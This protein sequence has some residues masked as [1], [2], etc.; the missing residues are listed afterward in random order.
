MEDKIAGTILG[1]ALGDALGA[2][3]E[4][5]PYSHYTGE[6]NTSIVRYTR[7]YGEQTSSIGQVTDDT[8]MA[9][10]LL[11]TIIGGYTRKKA[12]INYMTWAINDYPNCKG[13][14]PF[15]GK[16]TR[17]LFVATKPKVK[18]YENRFDKYYPDEK[19]KEDS[20][21]NGALMRSYPLAFVEDT[22]IIKIDVAISNPSSLTH[23]SVMAYIVAIKMA[24]KGETK[25]TIKSHV[26]TILKNELLIEVYLDACNNKF[27][28]VTTNREHVI[29]AFYCAFWGLF[30]YND[31]KTAIDA[32]ICLSPN[33]NT[34]AKICVKGAALKKNKVKLG[35]TDTNAAIA[36]ALLGAFYG[37]KMIQV[38]VTTRE[39]IETL[40]DCDPNKGDIK[41]PPGLILNREKLKQ[42][43]DDVN[44]LVTDT[45]ED[46]IYVRK[47]VPGDGWC[48]MHAVDQ[49]LKYVG[50]F[51]KI[52]GMNEVPKTLQALAIPDNEY[53]TT[54]A[55][56]DWLQEFSK[57]QDL[58]KVQFDDGNHSTPDTACEYIRM[59]TNYKYECLRNIFSMDLGKLSKKLRKKFR[60]TAEEVKN[61][62]NENAQMIL[63]RENLDTV[64]KEETDKLVEEHKVVIFVNTGMHWEIIYS[65]DIPTVN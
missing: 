37:L 4:F 59:K 7:A 30:N 53:I 33:E 8:E 27:R 40:L 50:V 22:D 52:P 24:L 61:I 19:S 54:P 38:N 21:S 20:Q 17:N 51:D 56:Q 28:D 31:Y 64:S 1:H 39:N 60:F 48:S 13:T 36:G 32:I 35:D 10:V 43:T 65:P 2:P 15:M 41:R 49:F 3:V 47:P 23:E 6:L 58:W 62:I 9:L 16:N 45:V 26:K 11:D 46:T 29:H 5:F 18:S 12:I 25:E 44:K 63:F 55:I 34:P 42:I 57:N 14:S